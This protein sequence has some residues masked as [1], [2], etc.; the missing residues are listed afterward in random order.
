[1]EPPVV[2][3]QKQKKIKMEGQPKKQV[4]AFF[5]RPENQVGIFLLWSGG[6]IVGVQN[7]RVH[8]F[9][10]PVGRPGYKQ[11]TSIPEYLATVF[12]P[13]GGFTVRK[14]IAAKG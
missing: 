6:H 8:E 7:G 13:V 14:Y 10:P 9:S 2:P 11:F 3:G 4:E 12:N 5:A 1:M